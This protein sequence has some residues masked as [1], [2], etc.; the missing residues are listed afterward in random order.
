MKSRFL[1]KFKIYVKKSIPIN[2]QRENMF[3]FVIYSDKNC[4]CMSKNT[5]LETSALFKNHICKLQILK[6]IKHTERIFSVLHFRDSK[7]KNWF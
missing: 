6:I 4:L 5:T 1:T 7:E 2:C 3:V